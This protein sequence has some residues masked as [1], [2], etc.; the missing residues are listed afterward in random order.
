[1]V[2]SLLAIAA[3]GMFVFLLFSRVLPPS[4]ES[5]IDLLTGAA[6]TGYSMVLAYWLG[7]SA[8]SAAKDTTVRQ[9]SRK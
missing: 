4:M 8:G 7:S 3:F 1:V 6:L 2:V 9:M 5:R